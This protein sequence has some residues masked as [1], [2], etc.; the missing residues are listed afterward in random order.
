[1][2]KQL[3]ALVDA[4]NF[5][6]SCE[7]LFN[8]N[9]ENKPVIVL[10][11]NDGCAVSRS[12]EAKDLWVKMGAPYFMIQKIFGKQV[13][14]L[15]SNYTLYGEM[16]SRFH[17]LVWKFWSRQEV[18][19]IDESFIDV[20]EVRNIKW[21][22]AQ[23]YLHCKRDLGLPVCVGVWASKTLAKFANHIAK[24]N[25]EF[26]GRCNF[27]DFSQA[28]KNFWMKKYGVEDIW[29]IG[30]QMTDKLK[31]LGIMTVYDFAHYDPMEMRMRFSIVYSKMV[32]ELNGES[33]LEIEEIQE[34]KK[35]IVTSRSFWDMVTEIE[36]LS[37]AISYFAQKW[38]E[39][40]R[41]QWSKANSAIVFI[42]SNKFREDL[43][44]FWVSKTITF[45]FPT[46]DT[47]IIIPHCIKALKDIFK[48]GIYY[49]KAGVIFSDFE[50]GNNGQMDLFGESNNPQ[51]EKLMN[52]VDRI[53]EK[54]KNL[55]FFGT[56][57]L[58][59]NWGMRNEMKSPNYLHDIKQV[60][61]IS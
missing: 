12:Q 23:I 41:K 50:N 38:A 40:L 21:Q 9:L 37:S 17:R 8:P 42:R 2:Q 49:K 45:P 31:A 26:K 43:D 60:P 48:S 11:N 33:C 47:T 27:E 14:A 16:S 3:Y 18:Y 36:D 51:K 55:I 39:K 13:I 4:N 10:S 19:S 5:Y 32:M 35:Q 44:Q 22:M 53:N 52:V 20:M 24:K 57:G 6:V 29:G 34:K 59:K 58:N 28:E 54:N 30:K 25:P 15:S 56:S 46:N 7:R 61:C 1:M